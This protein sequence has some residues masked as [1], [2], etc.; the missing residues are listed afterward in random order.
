MADP[1]N[2]INCRVLVEVVSDYLEDALPPAD[3]AVFERHLHGCE[4]CRRYLHQMR[5]TIRTV[6]H[7]REDDLPAEMRERLLGVFR[8][9]TQR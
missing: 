5:T 4:G 3:V 1:L 2:E 9:L 8:E 7:L 6:G